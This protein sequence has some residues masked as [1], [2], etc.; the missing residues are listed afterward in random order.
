MIVFM[1]KDLYDSDLN[2]GCSITVS[3]SRDSCHDKINRPAK[4]PKRRTGIFNIMK[5]WNWN[6][7]WR[8]FFRHFD[9]FEKLFSRK[10]DFSIVIRCE[11]VLHVA[12]YWARLVAANEFLRTFDC[13]KGKHPDKNV[14]EKREYDVTLLG[15]HAFCRW[16]ITWKRG[17]NRVTEEI[18]FRFFG[19]KKS[20]WVR[21]KI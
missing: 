5:N 6:S 4:C 10:L 7:I 8:I 1:T 9:D 15:F 19:P 16:K 20:F 3:N 17:V 2:L 14:N 21:K 12:Y 11:T 18:K 13:A